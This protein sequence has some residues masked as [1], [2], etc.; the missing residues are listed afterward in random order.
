MNRNCM[1]CEK[2]ETGEE[3]SC[4]HFNNNNVLGLALGNILN[5]G[6]I[7]APSINVQI[8]VH[9]ETLVYL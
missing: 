4:L 9:V 8:L 7:A 3:G 5:M 1:K 2:P 6:N